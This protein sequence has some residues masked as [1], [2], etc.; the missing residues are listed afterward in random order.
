[1]NKLA[2]KKE[3]RTRELHA[4]Y[5]ESIV[6]SGSFKREFRNSNKRNKVPKSGIIRYNADLIFVNAILLPQCMQ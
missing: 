2:T 4:G 1:M 6:R 5:K 3:I